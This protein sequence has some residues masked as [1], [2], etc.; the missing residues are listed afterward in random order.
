[1]E[2]ELFGIIWCVQQVKTHRENILKGEEAHSKKQGWYK[3][4]LSFKAHQSNVLKLAG[5]ATD[6][7]WYMCQ[8]FKAQAPLHPST[9]FT[10]EFQDGE[11][12]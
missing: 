2:L 4:C 1:M 3:F 5:L 10:L 6:A 11:L 9:S 8:I 12:K 7:V